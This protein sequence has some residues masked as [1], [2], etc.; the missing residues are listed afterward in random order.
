MSHAAEWKVRLY[1]SEEDRTTKARVEVDTGKTKLTGHGSARCAPQD[2]DVPAIG[3][4]LA[5]GR[6]ME[7]LAE[8]LKRTAFGDMQAMGSSPSHEESLKPYAGWLEP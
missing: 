5:A 3:D 6:A 1:L 2:R 8:Q 4:E 7:N